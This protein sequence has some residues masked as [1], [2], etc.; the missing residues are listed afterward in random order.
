MRQIFPFSSIRTITVGFGIAPNLLT[1]PIARPALVGFR[2]HSP[3]PPVGTFTPPRERGRTEIRPM[4][5]MDLWPS[6][7]TNFR[8]LPDCAKPRERLSTAKDYLWFEAR[9]FCSSPPPPP[10]SPPTGRQRRSECHWVGVPLGRF[11]RRFQ[12]TLHLFMAGRCYDA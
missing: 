9:G 8:Q 5:L 7:A 11:D 6:N 12:R 2:D 3:L 1:P 4:R 10:L